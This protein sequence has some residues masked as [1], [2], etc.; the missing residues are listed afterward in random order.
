MAKFS[1][2]FLGGLFGAALGMLLAPKS[3]R[4]LRQSLIGGKP[5]ALPPTSPETTTGEPAPGMTTT[6]MMEPE[7]AVDLEERLEESRRQVEAEL[8]QAIPAPPETAVEPEVKT[9]VEEEVEE[10][11]EDETEAGPEPAVA[12]PETGV[13]EKIEAL[14][15][16]GGEEVPP[17][18]QSDAIRPPV[19]RDEMR[20]RIEETRSRLKAKAFDSMV[21]GE[22]LLAT[23]DDTTPIS[24]PGEDSG[25]DE[26]T[27]EI[28]DQLLEEED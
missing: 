20:Q 24:D 9:A 8:S 17:V 15:S 6:A 19:D 3:G 22:T 27:D 7:T 18:D 21:E 26:D 1:K 12:E 25:L 5:P 28:I 2:F 11:A 4:E 13:E 14:D 23:G 16:G 10:A